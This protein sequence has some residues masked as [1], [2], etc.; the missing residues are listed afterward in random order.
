M[1]VFDVL[2]GSELCHFDPSEG[3]VVFT[4]YWRSLL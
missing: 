2:A 1:D 3:V 4:I